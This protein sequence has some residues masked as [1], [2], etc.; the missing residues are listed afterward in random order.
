LKPPPSIATAKIR[1]IIL[2]AGFMRRVVGCIDF[3]LSPYP[4]ELGHVYVSLIENRFEE[5]PIS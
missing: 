3:L 5:N 4:I 1:K 2:A